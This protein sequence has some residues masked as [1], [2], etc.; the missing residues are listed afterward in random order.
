MDLLSFLD[1]LYLKD[2]DILEIEIEG[3][4]GNQV[5]YIR[6][7][8]NDVIEKYKY[9]LQLLIIKGFDIN[10]NTFNEKAI[11]YRIKAINPLYS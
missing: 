8:K 2:I 3:Q 10:T 6:G 9:K 7:Y 4:S 1:K 11:E 5:D